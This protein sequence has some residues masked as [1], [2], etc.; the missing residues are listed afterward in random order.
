MREKRKGGRLGADNKGGREGR[1][2][3][4]ITPAEQKEMTE[5]RRGESGGEGSEGGE[6]QST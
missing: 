3:L 1:R 2:W 4:K 5:G 6:C